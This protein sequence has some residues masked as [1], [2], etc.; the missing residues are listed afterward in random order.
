MEDQATQNLTNL[1]KINDYTDTHAS[2]YKQVFF[3][4]NARNIK[5]DRVG[6][7]SK[8]I[9]NKDTVVPIKEFT[10]LHTANSCKLNTAMYANTKI[11]YTSPLKYKN[12]LRY[13]TVIGDFAGSV[14]YFLTAT[15]IK[16]EKITPEQYVDVKDNI[17]VE[18]TGYIAADRP[19]NYKVLSKMTPALKHVFIWVGNNALK[20]YRPE[21]AMYSV[22]NYILKTNTSVQLVTG[23]YVAFRMQY[24]C[25][26]GE[27]GLSV[28]N[29]L[30]NEDQ[31][32]I[33]VF[34][35]NE[36]DAASSLYY[37]SLTPHPQGDKYYKC[38]VYSGSG[39]KV[40][41]NTTNTL[42]T[43]LVWS[44]DLPSET[45]YVSLDTTGNLNAYNSRDEKIATLFQN[46][47]IDP[48]VKYELV[49]DEKS[50]KPFFVRNQKMNVF[51][52]TT[53]NVVV[54]GVAN[55][56]LKDT[57]TYNM[58]PL[59][60]DEKITEDKPFF[61]ENFV[62][63]VAIIKNAVGSK[64][65]ALLTS[66]EDNRMFYTADADIKMNKLF[67]ASTFAENRFL[68]EVPEDLQTYGN[69]TS[70]Y[71][72]KYPDPNREYVTTDCKEVCKTCDHF[73]KVAD[74]KC[75][76]PTTNEP[77]LF[78]PKQPG[79]Q[80]E[81]SE[82]FIKNKVI[83]TRDAEKD[84]IY[85]ST[86]YISNGYASDRF[87]KYPIEKTMLSKNDL[88]GP[89]GMPDVSKLQNIVEQNTF[90]VQ[91]IYNPIINNPMFAGKIEG[92]TK[93]DNQ[94][95]ITD[96]SL[97]LQTY[98]GYQKQILKNQDDIGR[99][100]GNIDTV[101]TEM[102]NDNMKYDFTSKNAEGN[103]ILYALGED[104]RSLT[105]AL[106]KDNAIYLSEQNNLY[107]IGTVTMATLLIT[108]VLISK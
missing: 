55:D 104:D 82:L 68:K 40:N 3:K 10:G 32:P 88:P 108:A 66:V 64:M 61:S 35:M 45:A 1:K 36:S 76:N 98:A 100:I 79:S 14:N 4:P 67:Y 63:K 65:L 27:S 107:L 101:Y 71:K 85:D 30:A 48:T 21:N 15:V 37:Y 74:N 60:T 31:T 29:L 105:A 90:G 94:Q 12:G 93:N 69:T 26:P 6:V 19:G 22:D 99:N 78:L 13:L 41:N 62:Y 86:T 2:D 102:S 18:I 17:S 83:K 11:D 87:S 50:A 7:Y 46:P 73:Y 39:L 70:S 44:A 25:K 38:S 8:D 57:A 51:P 84:K 28:L 43:R 52:I 58:S 97:N 59:S 54:A 106:V 20:T 103:A 33:R 92:F 91:K 9:Y 23:E 81:T 72:G 16:D 89:T 75:L 80:Y 5:S 24:T 53:A 56:R 77:I 34:A 96:I 95:L 49:L 42:Q 47:D